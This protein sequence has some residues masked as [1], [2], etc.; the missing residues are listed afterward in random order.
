M[1]VTNQ[2][3]KPSGVTFLRELCSLI[4][5]RLGWSCFILC[6]YSDNYFQL[7]Q[8]GT[9]K[10]KGISFCLDCPGLCTGAVVPCFMGSWAV[11]GGRG[12]MSEMGG[13]GSSSGQKPLCSSH[14]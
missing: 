5:Y 14:K 10:E 8:R 9:L 6:L 1:C 4:H 3:C 7:I 2:L 11:V 12:E 13:T